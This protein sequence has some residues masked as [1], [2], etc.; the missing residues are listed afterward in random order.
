MTV[1]GFVEMLAFPGHL[2]LPIDVRRGRNVLADIVFPW[3][4]CVEGSLDNAVAMPGHAY[5]CTT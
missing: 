5:A 1:W 4:R 3:G 2:G